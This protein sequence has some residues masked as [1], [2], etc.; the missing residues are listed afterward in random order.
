MINTHNC[1]NLPAKSL[2][3]LREIHHLL[4]GIVLNGVPCN[5]VVSIDR[6]LLALGVLET[7]RQFCC[8]F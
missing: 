5:L 7:S 3:V 1:Q 2:V 8:F 6:D 4:L